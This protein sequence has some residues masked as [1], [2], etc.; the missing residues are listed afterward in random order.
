MHALYFALAFGSV[1]SPIT[2]NPFFTNFDN[3]ESNVEY[4][5]LTRNISTLSIN[6]ENKTPNMSN[7]SQTIEDISVVLESSKLYIAYLIT[8]ALAVI[9]LL[10]FLVMLFRYVFSKFE[11]SYCHEEVMD[12]K[13]VTG[14]KKYVILIVVGLA[15]ALLTSIEESI[16]DFLPSFCVKQMHWTSQNGAFVVSVFRIA[17]AVGRLLG[18][19]FA[20]LYYSPIKVALIHCF[21]LIASFVG[22]TVSGIYSVDYGVWISSAVAGFGLSVLAPCWMNVTE[23][24]FFPISGKIATY[25]ITTASFGYAVVALLIGYLMEHIS[26]MYFGYILLSACIAFTVLLFVCNALLNCI[27]YEEEKEKFAYKSIQ[28]ITK[29]ASTTKME[30]IELYALVQARSP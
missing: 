19:L 22:I 23:E 10:P 13:Y 6:D 3:V 9:L 17:F 14:K 30:D 12:K 20:S 15:S 25:F 29:Y 8:A 2:M 27:K 1:L 18:I 4:R 7:L 5:N 28:D 11:I 26:D 16:S 24:N 21:V